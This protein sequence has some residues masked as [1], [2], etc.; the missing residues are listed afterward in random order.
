MAD[1]T[2]PI[3]L[4]EAEKVLPKKAITLKVKKAM[5]KK[6]LKRA[7]KKDKEI[8]LKIK[9]DIES[10]DKILL[11]VSKRLS[12]IVG[13]DVNIIRALFVVSSVLIIGIPIY[14]ILSLVLKED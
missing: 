8:S 7:S 14:F 3:E 11:G 12:K 6:K 13:V 5:P 10:T 9:R 4:K 2:T 1:E